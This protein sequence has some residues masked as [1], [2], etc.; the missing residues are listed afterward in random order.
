[1]NKTTFLFIVFLLFS[2]PFLSLGMTIPF[3]I[4]FYISFG[5]VFTIGIAHGSV[6]NLIY[7]K[8]TKV[9]PLKF[10][11][12]YLLLVLLFGTLWFVFPKIAMILFLLIS[13]YHFG[14]SQLIDALKSINLLKQLLFFI[15]GVSILSSLVNL[16]LQEI[17]QVMSIYPDMEIFVTSLDPFF[18]N[19][20]HIASSAATI[21]IL[22]F[23]HYTK[24]IS[25]NRMFVE[26]YTLAILNVCFLILPVLLG[27]TFYFIFLH[28]LK[29]LQDE[30]EYFSS[31]EKIKLIDFVKKL[32]PN[33]FISILGTSLIFLGIYLEFL[34]LSYG[35]ALIILISS[36]TFPH[37][38]VMEKFYK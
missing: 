27:F 4:Q 36:I 5:F 34:N 24:R 28:S 13:A 32:L 37:L 1:M 20:I 21:L 25:N 9:K 22:I 16:N 17:T 23:Y 35:F 7:L 38:F 29:V 8:K 6:D 14:Q 18:I 33:T 31:F 2:L 19:K 15:W 30:F 3:E 26:I 10:Y 12:I 11:L